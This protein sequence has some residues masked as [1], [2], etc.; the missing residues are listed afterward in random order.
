MLG[1][2]C[3]RE[4]AMTAPGSTSRA[5]PS[6]AVEY[7]RAGLALVPIPLGKKGP[8]TRGWNREE[9]AV[10]TEGAAA[11][12][13][14]GNIGLAH[15]WSGTGALDV[16]NGNLAV[17]WLDAR[18]VDVRALLAAAD[19]V[20]VVSGRPYRAKLLYR[21]PVGIEWLPTLKPPG[22]GLELRCATGDGATTVQDLLPPSVHPDTGREY[23]WKGDWRAIPVLPDAL[24]RV[25]RD[26][27][28]NSSTDLCT[29]LPEP[30]DPT[31]VCKEGERTTYLTRLAGVVVSRSK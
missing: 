14:G 1:G 25:W 8:I 5:C 20:E 31:R 16:D 7:V 30:P 22:S 3:Q 28:S 18:G 6:I 9:N 12:L 17:P 2:P 15:R 29:G 19:A 24:L 26:G 13:N 11:K 10:R 4:L 23:A 21:L 27:A